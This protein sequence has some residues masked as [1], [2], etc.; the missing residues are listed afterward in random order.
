MTIGEINGHNSVGVS[1]L[2]EDIP[3]VTSPYPIAYELNGLSD[4]GDWYQIT[5]DDNWPGCSGFGELTEIWDNVQGSG[6]VNCYYPYTFG[7]GSL[8]QLELNFTSSGNVCLDFSIAHTLSKSITCTAQPDSG[9]KSWVFLSSIANSNGYYTGPMTEIINLTASSCPDYTVMPR[10]NYLY[11]SGFWVTQETPWSDEFDLA[12]SGTC[13]TSGDPL[14]TFS[15]GD[16]TTHIV[17]TASGTSYGPHYGGGQNLSMVN[18]SFG[19]RY[20]TDPVPINSVVATASETLAATGQT[21]DLNTSVTGGSKPYSALWKNDTAWLGVQPSTFPWLVP[22]P[23]VYNFTAYGIDSAQTVFGPS[24][25]L[26]ID[27]PGPLTVGAVVANGG[28]GGADVGQRIIISVPIHGG[29]APYAVAWSGLPTGCTAANSSRLACAPTTPGPFNIGV[30]V[31]DS[32]HTS[33]SALPVAFRVVSDVAASL[34]APRLLYDEGQSIGFTVNATGGAGGYTYSWGNLPTGCASLTSAYDPCVPNGTGT[35]DVSTRVTDVYAFSVVT[36]ALNISVETDPQVGIH[37]VKSTVEVGESLS[38][39]ATVVGGTL[40]YNVTWSGLPAGCASGPTIHL[41][42]TPSVT[43]N[44]TISATVHDAAQFNNSSGPTLLQVFPQL[45]V[46]LRASPTSFAAGG[47][48]VVSLNIVGGTPKLAAQWTGVPSFCTVAPNGLSASCVPT[49]PGTY[50]LSVR[51]TDA[52]G[53]VKVANVTFTEFS[54]T[55][56]G[57]SGGGGLGPTTPWLLLLVPAVIVIV[58]VAIVA[59]RRRRPPLQYTE[60]EPVDK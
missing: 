16:P 12:G 48:T 53:T 29:Y 35:F 34:R 46:T 9:G 51:V 24:N 28:L 8:I 57:P 17:D 52:I 6:P 30:S 3:V 55:P 14:D 20:A 41:A 7:S 50:S 25:V 33:L 10:L 45:T 23:G 38:A 13:Y 27:V 18:T 26:Q 1:T 44:F 19:W 56:T 37:F 11:L 40:P 47:S 36:N 31:T 15:V 4:T 42:C 59:G 2:I 32:N 58:V 60:P 43:G 49:D 5:V 39:T 22:A 54:P 21:V